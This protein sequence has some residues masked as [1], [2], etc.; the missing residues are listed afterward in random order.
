MSGG[1]RVIV[2]G[3]RDYF[4]GD[5]IHNTLCD[6][7]AERGPITCVIHGAATGADTEGMIWAQTMATIRKVTHAPFRADW[8]AHG[9]AAGPIRN[10]RMLDEGRPDL[11][12]A[13]PGGKGTADMV[14]RARQAGI[15]VIEI[16]P[17]ARST[18]R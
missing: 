2:C 11:V 9:K 4:D 1:M 5:H 15:E 6:I 14:S 13:F 10:Q 7:D 17:S 12:I 3:G 8:R 18:G 16:A